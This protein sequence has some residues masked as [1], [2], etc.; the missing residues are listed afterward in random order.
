[1]W[2]VHVRS[3]GLVWVWD[4]ALGDK[5]KFEVDVKSKFVAGDKPKFAAIVKPQSSKLQGV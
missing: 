3:R 2:C 5:P 1:M 4:F